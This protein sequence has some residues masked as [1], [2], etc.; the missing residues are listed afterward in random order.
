M[1]VPKGAKWGA[2][3][4]SLLNLSY[5]M[6]RIYVVPHEKLSDGRVQ[7]GMASIGLDFPTGIMRGRF[8]PGDGQLYSIGMFAWAGNKNQDGGF[9]RIR[10]TGKPTHLPVGLS[11]TKEGMILRFTDPLDATSAAS[12]AN[13][14]VK[15]WGLQR[16]KNYGS[17]HI[18]E[19]PLQVT[20]TKLLDDGKSV[21]ITLPDIT[22]TW[23]M[24]IRYEL[25]DADSTPFKGA[26][27]NTIHKLAD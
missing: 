7:G 9:Y 20:S 19:H 3:N 21:L 26:V 10:H 15:A 2:L 17:P 27:N 25:K 8:H 11:A 13:Y 22:P 23:C 6:G 24:E 5:G 12:A 1:W 18:N 14:Q 4:G 16:T